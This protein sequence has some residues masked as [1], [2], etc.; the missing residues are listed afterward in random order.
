MG[1]FVVS[2]KE[3]S[4]KPS[5]IEGYSPFFVGPNR[6]QLGANGG[7]IDGSGDNIAEL[8]SSFC[9]LTALYWVWK[10]CNDQLKGIVHYRRFFESSDSRG[11]LLAI[12]AAENMLAEHDVIVPEKYWLLNTVE[13]HY[14]SHHNNKDFALLRESISAV[15]PSY[16]EVFDDCMG[17]RYVYPYNMLVAK[18]DVYDAYCEWLFS[19]MFALRERLLQFE[20]VERDAYQNRVYG[21][22]SERL[23]NVY[24][25]GSGLNVSENPVLLTE[26][27]LKRSISMGL[28]KF[29]YSRG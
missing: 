20:D 7:V 1:I 8:N 27:N 4:D 14:G 29:F 18:A 12:G 10:N 16:L 15:Q 23:M 17:L 24:I 26:R 2:H 21:F 9:E 13:K 5:L 22:L 19:I 11:S 3:L 28:A 6:I 25:A